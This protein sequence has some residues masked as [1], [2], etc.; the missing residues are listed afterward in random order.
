MILN[1]FYNIMKKQFI[2][3][4]IFILVLGLVPVNFSF[5]IT[6][7]Q[8]NAEVQIVCPDSYGNIFSGSGT[9]I[10]SKGI[11]LTNK[12][13]V[14]DEKNEII[15]TCLVGFTESI[16]EKP[17]FGTKSNPNLA[18]VKYHTNTDDMDAA[19]LYLNNPT[20]KLYSY[21]NI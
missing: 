20:N 5:A 7:N 12:H 14:T 2:I 15:K 13:V 4:L 8:I 21:I 11:I 18:E 9:I 16:N 10:D 3:F 19:I 6:Q 17:N 1:N